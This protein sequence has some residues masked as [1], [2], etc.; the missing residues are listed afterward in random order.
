MGPIWVGREAEL[1]RLEALLGLA[2]EGRGGSALILGRAGIGKTRLL[3]QVTERARERG[4]G[5][6]WGRGWELGQ[7]PSFWP[8]LELLRTSFERPLAPAALVRRLEPLLAEVAPGASLGGTDDFRLFDAVFTYLRAHARAE[9]LALFIDDVHAVDPSSLVL[10]EFLARSL[11]GE[12]VMLL[13]SQRLLDNPDPEQ[14]LRLMRLKRASEAIALEALTRA[15]VAAWMAQTTGTRDSDSVRRIHDASD[16]NPFFLS[17]LSRLPGFVQSGAP[18]P[19]SDLPASLRALIRTRLGSLDAEQVGVLAAAALVGRQFTLPLPAEVAEVSS[20]TLLTVCHAAARIGVLV[21]LAPGHYR[22][23]HVLVAEALVLELEPARAARWHRR[24]AEALERRFADDP[25]APVKEIARHWLGGGV[26]VAPRAVAAAARAARQAVS[27]LAF[28]DAAELYER[29]L[30]ALALCPSLD[31]ARQGELLV[32]WVEALSRAGRRERAEAVCAQTVALA[33]ARRDAALLARAALALGA[34]SRL[35]NADL[36]VSRLLMHALAELPEGDGELRAVASARLASARQPELDPEGPMILAREAIAMA[37]RIGTPAL[38]LH[39]IHAA[40]GALMDFAPAEER[41]TLNAEALALA[42]RVSDHPRALASAQRLA[43]DQLELGDL[44]GFERALASYE[45]LGAELDQPRYAW[46]PAMFRAM[47]AD[48]EGDRERAERWE[49]T[50]RATRDQ[51]NDEGDALVPVRQLGR[52]LLF[53]DTALLD[54]FVGLLL[55]R[56]PESSGALWLSALLAA[57]R[58]DAGAALV[59][60]DTLA[61]RGFGGLM[62]RAETRLVPNGTPSGAAPASTLEP[63]HSVGLGYLHMPEVAV[64]LACSLGDA[65]W[66]RTLYAELSLSEGKPFLLTT[67]GFSLHGAVDHALMR[68][69]IVERRWE[70]AERHAARAVDL[71]T[72]LGA[73]PLLARLE[74]DRALLSRARSAVAVDPAPSVLAEPGRRLA[75][76]RAREP[77][78]PRAGTGTREAEPGWVHVRREGDYWTVSAH[79]LECRVQ[80]NRGMHMLERLVREPGREVHVL[81]LSGSPAGVGGTDAGEVLDAQA[82]EAYEH[83]LRELRSEM[84]EAASHNDLGRHERLASEAEALIR[85]LARGFGIGGRARRSG[86]AVERARI[87]VRRRLS[88]ALRRIRAAS[89]ALGAHLEASLRTGVFCVYTPRQWLQ[90]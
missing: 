82:R 34:E 39:V 38:S 23:T 80:D 65:V 57:W 72:R 8:W 66:A 43:F 30:D 9:P 58:G 44:H 25:A 85:E 52:A 79:G 42:T 63:S 64:E 10:A 21:A 59:R 45:A 19:L 28:S 70:A 17:E 54:G 89:P 4:F 75:E 49:R 46:V 27:K 5:V 76:P 78:N 68:L 55:V 67:L 29:A 35:G 71:C 84:D 15:D 24:A 90:S 86:S 40:L 11:S 7:A 61:G 6:A 83:R 69:C 41:A 50:A 12:R 73:R 33:R 62:G 60:L 13:F 3:E 20:E 1:R 51:G 47:R 14:E 74:R 77:G 87:N 32:A 31:A 26:E 48:W 37:R 81:E 18:A 88:L 16:G 22:F 53:E 36:T 56:A 2:A